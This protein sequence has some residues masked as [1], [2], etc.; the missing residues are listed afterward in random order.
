[1]E[2]EKIVYDKPEGCSPV[3]DTD[4]NHVCNYPLDHV[5]SHRVFYDMNFYCKINGIVSLSTMGKNKVFNVGDIN[6]ED[7]NE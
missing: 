1:M 4:D 7:R 2:L 5:C 6:M 3:E